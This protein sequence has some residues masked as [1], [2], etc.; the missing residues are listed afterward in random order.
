[1]RRPAP[2]TS[3]TTQRI[4]NA[5]E[6]ITFFSKSFFSACMGIWASFWW[7][8]WASRDGQDWLSG[9]GC[10]D[11]SA[12]FFCKRAR[13]E[14]IFSM[15]SREFLCQS[16]TVD[17]FKA[18]FSNFEIVRLEEE[19]LAMHFTTYFRHMVPLTR[20]RPT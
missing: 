7:G 6:K 2:L 16:V 20:S 4:K 8:I 19:V 9:G 13:R 17:C 11:P 15:V 12:V 3:R 10:S 14:L 5:K 1:M 18:S